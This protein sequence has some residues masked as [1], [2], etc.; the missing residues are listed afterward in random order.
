MSVTTPSGLIQHS[1]EADNQHLESEFNLLF[2]ALP[3]E[4]TAGYSDQLATSVLGDLAR[5]LEGPGQAESHDG[6]TATIVEST[7]DNRHGQDP[8]PLA[9]IE[10][11]SPVEQAPV[12]P[13][14]S[15]MYKRSEKPPRNSK[16]RIICKYNECKDRTFSKPSD[17]R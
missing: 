3:V 10:S 7:Q 2:P 16:G 1:F 4:T 5:T 17:W 14:K 8:A 12:P 11:A 6:L 13:H 9:M 15:T